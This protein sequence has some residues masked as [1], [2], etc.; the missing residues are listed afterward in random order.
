MIKITVDTLA[1]LTETMVFIFL[2]IGFVA[3]EHPWAE[4]GIGTIV[5]TLV[6][7][8]L[9]RGLNILIISFM[10]NRHRPEGNKFTAKHQ[11]VMW[12]AGL[13]G[14][15]AYALALNTTTEMPESG[16]VILLVTLVYA[17]FTIL[18]VSSVLHPIMTRCEVTQAA[19]MAPA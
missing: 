1:Y 14:A 9:A 5:L 13:R 15:M 18:G 12:V 6:N 7:L 3:F 19:K 2:G 8:N 10:V 16:R 17:L 4:C 11:L